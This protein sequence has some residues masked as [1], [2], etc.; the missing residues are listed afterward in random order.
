M[1]DFELRPLVDSDRHAIG[2]LIFRS[3]NVWYERRGCPPIFTA[4]PRS[5]EI[6][7]DV[8]NDLTPGRSVCAVC[9]ETGR[10]AG[11]CFFHPREHHV[12]LGIMTV[13]PDYFGQGIGSRLLRHIIDFTD[14]GG[15]PALR[16]TQSAI[17]VDSFSL[18]NKYG[19]VPRYAYQDMLIAV[20]Q[21]GTGFSVPGRD[22]VREAAV[23][24]VP[25]MAALEQEVSGIT[26]ELEYRYC[27]ENERGFWR[28]S[29]IESAS[30][31]VDGF[32]ISSQHP[33]SNMLGPAVTRTE[34]DALALLAAEL[35]H[36]PGRTPVFL[37]PM[38]KQAMVRQ[39]YDWGGRNCEM[40]FCQVRGQFTPFAR[41]A[42]R[43]SRLTA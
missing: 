37:V 33:A 9:S 20:P 39:V 2:E 36:H 13:H 14:R 16:L 24:D 18:Y 17:N 29:V 42:A 30:G 5:T 1:S 41:S 32:M 28:V 8:Y 38:D 15:F 3:V 35:D 11:S 6:Y 26:R 25:A 43:S 21:G 4:G 31:D 7:F 27:I 10:L 19:F 34:P 12:S 22:R 40:H 23:D